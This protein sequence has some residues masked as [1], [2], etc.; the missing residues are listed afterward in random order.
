MKM[1]KAK[2]D[3]KGF[4]S[5]TGKGKIRGSPAISRL[6]LCEISYFHSPFFFRCLPINYSLFPKSIKMLYKSPLDLL[7]I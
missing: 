3:R 1:I 2:D 4:E 6:P 5:V 7:S